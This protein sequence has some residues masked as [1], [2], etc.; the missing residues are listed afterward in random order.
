[1][2]SSRG[3]SSGTAR[4]RGS[5]GTDTGNKQVVAAGERVSF[6]ETPPSN[7]EDHADDAG[8]LSS[9]NGNLKGSSDEDNKDRIEQT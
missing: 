9:P 7:P 3:D 6:A 5:A 2:K 1:M 4:K 8:A